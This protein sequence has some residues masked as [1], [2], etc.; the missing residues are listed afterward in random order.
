M[1]RKYG[2]LKICQNCVL[3]KCPAVFKTVSIWI[4]DW[5][6]NLS[7]PEY[8]RIHWKNNPP[9]K[10]EAYKPTSI[11]HSANILS[12]GVSWRI[13]G[14]KIVNWHDFLYFQLWV[15]PITWYSYC[16]ILSANTPKQYYAAWVYGC[17][18]VGLFLVSTCFHVIASLEKSW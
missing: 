15:I 4:Q 5:M 6:A 10:G 9:A 16:M 13:S 11:E 2:D 1:K 3:P 7:R 12:H 18:L 14:W 17:V 8:F